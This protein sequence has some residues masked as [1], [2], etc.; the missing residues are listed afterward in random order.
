MK[1]FLIGTALV[2]SLT[3]CMAEQ[4][5]ET[6]AIVKNTTEEVSK[7]YINSAKSK[8]TDACMKKYNNSYNCKCMTEKVVDSLSKDDVKYLAKKIIKTASVDELATDNVIGKKV[9]SAQIQCM[10]EKLYK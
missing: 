6:K 4:L 1:K 8:I 9:V 3:G 7:V 10:L 5:Q 2:I